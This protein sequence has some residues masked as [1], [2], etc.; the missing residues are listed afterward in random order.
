MLFSYKFAIT[1]AGAVAACTVSACVYVVMKRLQRKQDT[2]FSLNIAER[3]QLISDNQTLVGDSRR[4]LVPFKQPYKM[5]PG[6]LGHSHRFAAAH[7]SAMNA[8]MTSITRS[9]GYDPYHISKSRE[10][11][12][13]TRFFYFAKDLLQHYQYDR[14]EDN[15]VFILTDVDYYVD[16]PTLLYHGKPVMMYTFCPTSSSGRDRDYAWTSDSEGNVTYTVSGGASYTHK[17]WDYNGDS[18]AVVV[19]HR[20]NNQIPVPSKHRHC[21]IVYNLEQRIVPGDNHHR[22]IC[23]TPGSIIKPGWNFFDQIINT[24][25]RSVCLGNLI[26]PCYEHIAPNTLQRRSPTSLSYNVVTDELTISPPGCYT[27]V[28][29]CGELYDSIRTRLNNKESRPVVGDVERLLKAA[30]VPNPHLAAPVIFNEIG[31]NLS[32]NIVSTSTLPTDFKPIGSLAT[33]DAKDIGIATCSPLVSNPS[34]YASRGV[35]SDEA[36]IKGRVDKPRNNRVP[37]KIYNRYANEFVSKL[38]PKAG[39]GF[40]SMSADVREAQSRPSQRARYDQFV[41]TFSSALP[42]SLSCFIKSEP[43]AS[44]NAPRN[45]TTNSAHVTVLLSTYTLVFKETVLKPLQWY[46]PGMTP[47]VII[48]RLAQILEDN[49]GALTSDYSRFDGSISEWMQKSIVFAVYL[50]W[51]N[52][53]DR[54]HLSDLLSAVFTQ[55]AHTATGQSFNPGYGTR[56][57]SPTTTDGNTMMNAFVQ[58]ATFR[59]M[60]VSSAEAWSRLGIYCGDDGM[61]AQYPGLA[62]ALKTTCADLGLSVEIIEQDAK[63][64]FQFCGRYFVDP[65]TTINSFQDPIRTISKLHLTSNKTVTPEQAA[66]NKACGYL[67]TDKHTPIISDW[68]YAVQRITGLSST[69]NLEKEELFKQTQSWPVSMSDYER[70]IDAFCDVVGISSQELMSIRTLVLEAKDLQSFPVVINNPTDH[71]IPAILGDVIVGD[72]S[73]PVETTNH[74]STKMPNKQPRSKQPGNSSRDHSTGASPTKAPTGS[75]PTSN[76]KSGG[77]LPKVPSHRQPRDGRQRSTRKRDQVAGASNN[78]SQSWRRTTAPKGGQL[79]DQT[80]SRR[81]SNRPRSEAGPSNTDTTGKPIPVADHRPQPGPS[82]EAN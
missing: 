75:V 59:N 16:M 44:A 14:V 10:D 11:D 17:L 50:R 22:F 27:S 5:F 32:P 21:M 12:I 46:S 47:A 58:Y 42:N 20:N 69:K 48:H 61:T 63:G 25:S 81:R 71:K 72:H 30:K 76:S 49:N 15:S 28:S 73:P 53:A 1:T 13:G 57:G 51:C 66:Y 65:T 2:L 6:H 4:L 78:S 29:L 23:F 9:S 37:S 55:K 26:P 79:P 41:D 82:R 3:S 68:C 39:Y 24:I 45:I 70:V 36:C 64:P 18:I 43:Y 35:N 34:I 80:P 19:D 62:E 67:V 74:V 56:S 77:T 54:Q 31:P 60:N 8:W 38:V 33:E 52:I 40:P 7:R